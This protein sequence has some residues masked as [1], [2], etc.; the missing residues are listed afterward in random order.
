MIVSPRYDS[1]HAI[2]RLLILYLC[3]L[4]NVRWEEEKEEKYRRRWRRGRKKE[5]GKE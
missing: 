4:A 5:E 2:Q 1:Q 3:L